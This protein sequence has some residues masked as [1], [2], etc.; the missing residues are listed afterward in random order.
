MNFDT[1]PITTARR[2]SL[3]RIRY[4]HYYVYK[5]TCGQYFYFG[6]RATN[7][8]PSEDTHYFSSSDVVIE[9]I[10][11]T[12]QYHK[13]IIDVF[14]NFEQMIRREAELVYNHLT[15]RD[16]LN[17][18]LPAEF[19]NAFRS[20]RVRVQEPFVQTK[21]IPEAIFKGCGFQHIPEQ[22]QL[23][24][25][26][27]IGVML[28]PRTDFH[29]DYYTQRGFEVGKGPNSGTTNGR[30][31]VFNPTT[32]HSLFILPEEVPAYLEAGYVQN[33]VHKRK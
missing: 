19:N 29:L 27:D 13:E 10:V 30:K 8:I 24:F 7:L 26:S 5:I 14:D 16:C 22:R 9:A 4:V 15:D 11:F 32:Q 12:K 31:Y 6:S 17:G 23:V 28:I 33:Q 18:S 1:I 21:V 3:K 20:K 25:R 2:D